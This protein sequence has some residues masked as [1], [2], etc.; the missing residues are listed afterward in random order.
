MNGLPSE[1]SDFQF[2]EWQCEFEAAMCERD[3]NRLPERLKL[4]RA[5]IFSRLRAK[6]QRPP[7]TLERIA[8]ND[9]I[10]LLRVVRTEID[11]EMVAAAER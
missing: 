5:A 6:T 7:G 8:L 3:G 10:H 9:A 4:A 11:P 2:P 1:S